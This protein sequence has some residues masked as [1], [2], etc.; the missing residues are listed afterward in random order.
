MDE[1]QARENV[2]PLGN[3][4]PLEPEEKPYP[5]SPLASRAAP[6]LSLGGEPVPL[7]SRT[8]PHH[9]TRLPLDGENLVAMDRETH[10]L[11]LARRQIVARIANLREEADELER[12]LGRAEDDVE[13]FWA[14]RFRRP[15][16]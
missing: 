14:R 1:K 3:V 13:S 12:R 8:A 2:R 11:A 7:A 5:Q 4:Y 16:R 9:V 15:R 10:E 6:N